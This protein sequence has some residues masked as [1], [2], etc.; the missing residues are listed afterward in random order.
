MPVFELELAEKRYYDK[1]GFMNKL[2][3][4]AIKSESI[5]VIMLS[6]YFYFVR[7]TGLYRRQGF[8]II[9]H[10]FIL[11]ITIMT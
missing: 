11:L 4:E 3:E 1:G 8:V 5:K 6:G 9:S 2:L 7:L 10:C